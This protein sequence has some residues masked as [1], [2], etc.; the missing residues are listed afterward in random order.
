MN[1]FLL[2]LIVPLLF[3]T[4]RKEN[5][6]IDRKALLERNNPHVTAFDS[7][8]SLSVGNG[9]FAVT[10]DVTGLQTFPEKYAK[11]MPLGTQA[12]W[13]WH[14]FENPEN[15]RFEETL[16]EYDFGHDGRKEPYSVQFNEEGR[17][18][19]AADWYRVNPHRLHLGILGLELDK[20]T[21]IEDITDIHQTLVLEKGIIESRYQL[22]GQAVEVET[23]VHP[24]KDILAVKL[25]SPL[26]PALKLRFP[27]PTGQH[28]DDACDWT[29]NDGHQTRIVM[30]MS[31]YA[32]LMRT[33]DSAVYFVSLEW[34][35]KAKF[36]EKEKNYFTITP[37][38]DSISITCSFTPFQPKE[39]NPDFDSVI[40]VSESDWHDFWYNGAAVDFSDC[41]DPRAKELERR[42]VLSQYLLAIQ[43]SGSTPPQETGLTYN[44]W[45]GKFHLEMIW[46][47]EAQFALWNRPQ[48]LARTMDWYEKA[49]PVA[50]KIAER[51][52]FKGIRWMKM[53]DPGGLEAPS[54]VGSFL[55]WQQPHYIY[56]AEL[57]YRDTPT[58][59]TL[60]KYYRWVQE[61]AE[62]MYDFATYETGNDRFVLR[63]I[64]PAQETLRA[65]ET[66]NPPFELSYWHLGMSLAQEWR[67][68]KGEKRVPEWDKLIEKLSPL[69]YD[70]SNLYLAAETAPDTYKDIRF[71]SDHP[72]VLGAL[73]ILPESRLVHKDLMLN[74]LNWIWD[75]WNWNETWGWDY[76]M[77]AMAATRLGEPDKA[78]GAL[79][80]D[81]RT[82]TYLING[83]NYQDA[84]LRVYLPGNG[85][86]LT[87]IA[88]MCAGWDGC[89][90]KNPGF[91]K[92]GNWNVKWEGLKPM[93]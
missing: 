36:A 57:L 32:I 19:A 11:G 23:C 27:Y 6:Q 5:E 58:D 90:E 87:A 54:K 41:T 88:M 63:G 61:T 67:K 28:T 86:L 18:K 73:G 53:T 55:I 66:V 7:L 10:V 31:N 43:C 93:I 59:S 65:A 84:R 72:A 17:Q 30:L 83:H 48:L 89:R 45:Y 29:Q 1:K 26:K 20:N 75:N 47:H 82:N 33:I 64:I 22:N 70:E 16:K 12:Q 38:E 40:A 46:W 9:E 44:S 74:T 81:K 69:A 34:E 85:G 56:L 15:Y 50:R 35:G 13:G 39:K 60:N 3:V 8:A 49:E 80:M 62:F 71:T 51:Q 2:L 76:P 78:I 21:D 42:V 68:R 25:H 24:R 92:D 14:S 37:E 79:L 77:V 91:P 4:C 52:G